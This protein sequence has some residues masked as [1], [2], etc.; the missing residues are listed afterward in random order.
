MTTITT[1]AS[2]AA[3]RS[4]APNS[5]APQHDALA[6]GDRVES[7]Y[8]RRPGQVVRIYPD[9]SACICWADGEP[10]EAGLG[11]ER[12]PRALLVKV[13]SA[14]AAP[15]H[16]PEVEQIEIHAPAPQPA[17]PPPPA[18]AHP[19]RPVSQPAARPSMAEREEYCEALFSLLFRHADDAGIDMLCDEFESM[20]DAMSNKRPRSAVAQAW[21]ELFARFY[22]QGG[23]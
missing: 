10:Q 1:P 22:V 23:V 18:E 7:I 16:A 3:L 11:N 12:M 20:L 8:A 14:E 19:G 5:A 13:G 4:A 21:A 2:T 6:A 9:G 15:A 17:D